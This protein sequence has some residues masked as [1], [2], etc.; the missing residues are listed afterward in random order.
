MTWEQY[1]FSKAMI[2]M[3]LIVDL[4]GH[5]PTEKVVR[6]PADPNKGVPDLDPKNPHDKYE[7]RP[8]GKD[9]DVDEL[10]AEHFVNTA[11][12]DTPPDVHGLGIRLIQLGVTDVIPE[13]ELKAAA[14]LRATETQQRRGEETDETTLEILIDRMLANAEKHQQKITWLQ[15][16][17]RVQNN[18]KKID[19][20]VV[21]VKSSGN[22][23]L[24]AAAVVG[25]APQQS[26]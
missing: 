7:V 18:R 10:D 16:Y 12:I 25:I 11:L 9:E 24:D 14:D 15:A 8:R 13:G 26:N 20:R 22:P 19:W 3:L 4:T 21:D 17:E 6:D 23:L 5:Q 1:A 2:S